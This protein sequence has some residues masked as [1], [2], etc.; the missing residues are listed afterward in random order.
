[1]KKI[2]SAIVAAVLCVCIL[3]SCG[4]GVSVPYYILAMDNYTVNVLSSY[5]AVQ[6]TVTYYENE[7][8]VFEYSVY[9]DRGDEEAGKGY[10]NVRESFEGYTFYA[11]EQELY[12][13]TGDKTYSV[14]TTKPGGYLDVVASYEERAHMLDAGE[15]FQKYSKALDDGTE[16]CY[17]VKVTP[18]MVSELYHFGITETDKILSK[19]ILDENDLYLSVEYSVERKDGSVE[20]IAERRFE[21]Y[22]TKSQSAEIFAGLSVSDERIDVVISY[23][24]GVTEYYKA[25]K[26]TYLGIDSPKESVSYYADEGRTVAFDFENTV[27]TESLTIYAK[28]A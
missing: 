15:K 8:A 5:A 22:D 6:E 26:G 1:M 23:E 19:Y 17:Y 7:E 24:N 21:Y 27:I 20:K 3:A 18:L 10:Y 12:T 2:I 25:A 14:L 28:N 11:Y 4:N 9:M 16:V 13:V